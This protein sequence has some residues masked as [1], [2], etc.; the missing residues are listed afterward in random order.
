VVPQP[1][2]YMSQFAPWHCSGAHLR[3]TARSGLFSLMHPSVICPCS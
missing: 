3:Y 1:F 2:G